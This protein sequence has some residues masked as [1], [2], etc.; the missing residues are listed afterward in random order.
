MN[1]LAA[2]YFDVLATQR[3]VEN[4]RRLAENAKEA[5]NVTQ[6]LLNLGQANQQDL[7]QAQVEASQARVAVRNAE[8]RLRQDWVHL[9]TQVG[10]PDL[11]M[12]PLVGRLEPDGPALNRDEALARL[13]QD[14][15]ELAFAVTKVQHGRSAGWPCQVTRPARAPPPGSTGPRSFAAK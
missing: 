6:Q 9:A 3:S 12:Q 14:S 8:T 10:V 5:E 1:G 15:P 11:T 7:L 13:L 4:A 2:G